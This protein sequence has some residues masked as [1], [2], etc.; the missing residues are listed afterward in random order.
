NQT[1]DGSTHGGVDSTRQQF[2]ADRAL[3]LRD[4]DEGLYHPDNGTQ[5]A[6]HGCRASDCRERRQIFLQFEYLEFRYVFDGSLDRLHW[7][8]DA[9]YSLLDHA[10]YRA[11]VTITQQDRKSTRLNSS[12]VKISYA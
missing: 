4:G 8:A 5:E 9:G 6:N 10:R 11:V 7:A 1:R 2:G 12:H 3:F